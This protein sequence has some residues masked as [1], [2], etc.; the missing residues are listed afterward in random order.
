VSTRQAASG[1]KG[2]FGCGDNGDA[3]CDTT[4]ALSD[5]VRTAR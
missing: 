5:L 2:S 3:G 1:G 4:I